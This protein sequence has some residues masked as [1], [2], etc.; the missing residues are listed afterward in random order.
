MA[1]R[2]YKR[3][4]AIYE[5][6]MSPEEK[7]GT[8]RFFEASIR[9]KPELQSSF[10][11]SQLDERYPVKSIAGRIQL[12]EQRRNE[13]PYLEEDI[14]YRTN[15]IK[16]KQAELG[17]KKAARDLDMYESQINRED[18]MLEQIP[19]ARQKLADL[20]VRDPN[21]INKAYDIQDEHPMAFE[22][23]EF[24]KYV[25]QPMLNRNSRLSGR[26]QEGI[27][28]DAD[29]KEAMG[30]ISKYNELISARGEGVGP[31]PEEERYLG[32][33][34]NQIDQ[35]YAQRGMENP[36]GVT[37]PQPTGI[38]PAMAPSGGASFSSIEEA[39]SAGLPA[40]TIVYINGRKA[41]ID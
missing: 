37:A 9:A 36:M 38:A 25:F 6:E 31:S 22:S 19:V 20:D 12:E 1:N 40:G 17:L 24:Q 4:Q 11:Y 32:F 2:R 23:Q 7:Y 34:Q 16:D 29:L 33:R 13:R 10:D 3:P 30:E 8:S 28:T 35:F 21:F 27:V 14:A 39:E 18:A 41:R 26:K 15:L 5:E